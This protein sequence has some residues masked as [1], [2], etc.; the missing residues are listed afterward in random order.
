[1]RDSL[2]TSMTIVLGIEISNRSSD[3]A[4]P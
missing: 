3:S 4:T 1:M 2:V